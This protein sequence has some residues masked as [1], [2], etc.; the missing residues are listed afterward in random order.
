MMLE[1]E[2]TDCG[3]RAIRLPGGDAGPRY[4]G[5]SGV[6][7]TVA[8]VP[9]YVLA[10]AGAVWEAVVE[11]VADATTNMRTRSGYRTVPIDEDAQILRFED[12]E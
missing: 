1:P 12:E 5:E 9:Y 10:L 3:H 7:E 2:L 11:R 8:S 6:L 4:R